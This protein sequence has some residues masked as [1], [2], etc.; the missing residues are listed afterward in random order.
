MPGQERQLP[1]WTLNPGTPYELCDTGAIPDHWHCHR[2]TGLVRHFSL[3]SSL[4]LLHRKYS[5]SQIYSSDLERATTSHGRCSVSSLC[6]S[7]SL[8]HSRFHVL[9][10]F[11]DRQHAISVVPDSQEAATNNQQQ[12]I[13]RPRLF[14]SPST[15]RLQPSSHPSIPSSPLVVRPRNR[16]RSQDPTNVAARPP[17]TAT[18]L[19]NENPD[20]R[21]TAEALKC[22]SSFGHHRLSVVHR[23]S[24][25]G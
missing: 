23:P 22:P 6:R 25:M 21:V 3:G 17:Y 16:S 7:I 15:L 24:I 9:T 19:G 10:A 20:G 12:P 14:A 11:C 18:Q 13:I 1:A 4:E 5:E 2:N 8:F